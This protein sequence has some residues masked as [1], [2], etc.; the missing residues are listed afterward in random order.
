M[1][2]LND[3]ALLLSIP[4]P[5]CVEKKIIKINIVTYF[6]IHN[7]NNI[8]INSNIIIITVPRPELSDLMM[9]L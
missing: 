9:M 7:N 8:I 1:S 3:Y 2:T 6:L 5:I 4:E